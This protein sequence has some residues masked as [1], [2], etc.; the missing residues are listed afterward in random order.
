MK[1]THTYE[2][3]YT[4]ANK[5]CMHIHIRPHIRTHKHK[6]ISVDEPVCVCV[7]SGVPPFYS[8]R[9]IVT[10]CQYLSL[11]LLLLPLLQVPGL[12]ISRDHFSHSKC[13]ESSIY[14]VQCTV[15]SVRC[16]VYTVIW[17][18]CTYYIMYRGSS[19]VHIVCTYHEWRSL[20]TVQFTTYN[21]RCTDTSYT[22]GRYRRWY[23]TKI[24]IMRTFYVVHWTTH[25]VRHTMYD[26]HCTLYIVHC[27]WSVTRSRYIVS[28]C[29]LHI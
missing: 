19:W 1:Y 14:D 15:Y 5:A 25:S 9:W 20:Y 18:Q 23:N 2:H 16:T 28:L 29:D 24:T 11:L 27:K 22:I 13:T 7:V 4:Y 6:H 3:I 8:N 17:T 10:S 21:V 26:V 12:Y